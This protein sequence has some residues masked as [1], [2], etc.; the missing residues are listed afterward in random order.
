MAVTTGVVLKSVLTA[1]W[2]NQ[3]HK[4]LGV[5]DTPIKLPQAY[6]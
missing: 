5:K 1:N 4:G 2:I 6:A 3:D